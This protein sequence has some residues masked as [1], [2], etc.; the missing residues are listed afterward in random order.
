MVLVARPKSAVSLCPCCGCQTGRVH[1]H[2]VRRLTDLPWQ[3]QVVE[4]R[5]HAR[6]FRCANPQCP[7]RIF[8][9]RLPATVRPKA[10][11]TTRPGESQLVALR[12][13]VSL[14]RACRANWLCRSAVTPCSE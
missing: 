14:A 6:R 7:R 5:L 9:E 4:I 8:T 11:R 10:R 2:Y 12:S 3:G 13:A 1:S